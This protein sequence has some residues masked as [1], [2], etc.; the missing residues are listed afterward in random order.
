MSIQWYPGHMTSAK[1][2]AE[3]A[4][5]FNDLVIEVLDAR[6]P[7]SST[8]P[9]IQSLRQA[10]QRPHL[11][12]L[13]KSDLADPQV[14]AQWLNYFNQQPKTAAIT[15][16][17]K[18][19]REVKKILAVCQKLAPHRGTPVKPLRMLIMGV[20]NV[21]KSTIINALKN[22]RIAKVGNEPA[23]TKMQQRI[24]LNDHMV[25]TDT[26]G[27]MWPKITNELD[28][29]FLAASH[30]IGINAYDE[31]E[32]ALTLYDTIK[33]LYPDILAKH[34]KITLPFPTDEKFLEHLAGARKFILKK[35]ELDL[36]K[37]AVTFLND[38][39]QGIIGRMSLESPLS[40]IAMLQKIYDEISP[41]E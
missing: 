35:G 39:R 16:S 32:T 25:L 19:V 3:E 36:H 22:K 13:N 21:G 6:I 8:N 18:D 34:Y 27:M 26:P 1:K 9:M 5:E 38:Y 15:L 37:A 20:P 12:I 24:E 40:R 2:K 14:T 28:G 10:R 23:V 11:K 41:A 29:I 30:S 17:A 4:M 33:K 31:L 7:G